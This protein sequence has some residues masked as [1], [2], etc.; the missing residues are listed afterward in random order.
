MIKIPLDDATWSLLEKEEKIDAVCDAF[1]AA[2][3]NGHFPRVSDYAA[4]LKEDQRKDLLR[5][6]MM[7]DKQY[8]EREA[9]PSPSP[10]QNSTTLS[11]QH[12]Q[13]DTEHE[14]VSDVPPKEPS[15]NRFELELPTNFGDF[16]L[17]K[18]L[19]KGSF[20]SVYRAEN[21]RTG[22]DVAIKIPHPKLVADRDDY[23][24]FE[25]EARNVAKLKHP[26]AVKIHH[27]GHVDNIPFLI[28][29]YIDGK[30]LKEF[31]SAFGK[32]PLQVV[33]KLMV[34]LAETVADAHLNGVI[35]RDIKPSNILIEGLPKSGYFDPSTTSLRPRLLDFGIAKLSGSN[36]VVTKHGVVLGTPAYMSPEQAKGNSRSV[37]ARSDIYSLGVVMYELL[38]G[39]TPFQ[40]GSSELVEQ[41]QNSEVPSIDT[42]KHSVPKDL[43]TI[44]QQAL[45]LDPEARYVSATEFANDL[46]RW[47]NHEPIHGRPFRLTEWLIKKSTKHRGE[48]VA[49][50]IIALI[51][52]A[53][54][55]MLVNSQR[56][57]RKQ[58]AAILVTDTK[59]HLGPIAPGRLED[60]LIDLP[61]S[62][63]DQRPLMEGIETADPLKL[64]K[65]GSALRPHQQAAVV[66][67]RHAFDA[68]ASHPQLQF[69]IACIQGVVD[70]E[71]F[72]S[73]G[74]SAQLVKWLVESNHL[75]D[76]D[77]LIELTNT[78]KQTLMKDLVALYGELNSSSQRSSTRQWLIGLLKDEP[79]ANMI[80]AMTRCQF[81]ELNEWKRLL[82]QNVA[83][84]LEAIHDKQLSL[85]SDF[86]H[87]ERGEELVVMNAKLLLM[88]YGLSANE[89]VWPKLTSA[90]DPRLRAYFVHQIDTTGF[91]LESLV[92][93]L[94]EESDPSIQYAIL[95]AISQSTQEKLGTSIV[96]KIRPWLL[97]AYQS[98]PDCG[99]HGMCR[100]ILNQ[101]EAAEAVAQIDDTLRTQGIINGRNWYVN[102]IGMTML[103]VPRP[104]EFQMAIESSSLSDATQATLENRRI[105]WAFAIATDEVSV[106]QYRIYDPTFHLP[107]DG[108]L[109]LEARE[110]HRFPVSD[111][112]WL[113]AMDFCHWLSRVEGVSEFD[114][115]NWEMMGIETLEIDFRKKGYRLPTKEE[116]EYTCRA[117]TTTDCSYGTIRT[118]YLKFYSSFTQ[119]PIDFRTQTGTRLPNGFGLF[120]CLGSVSE[121]TSSKFQPGLKRPAIAEFTE[122]LAIKKS[123]YIC[124]YN[125]LPKTPT[126]FRSI[127][128]V[129]KQSLKQTGFR[130]VHTLDLPSNSF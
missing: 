33:A 75:G 3:K 30:E 60:W 24:A 93:R 117:L 7:V 54:S 95:V 47:L 77:R 128:G 5:E 121:M 11:L 41:V 101:W 124:G 19:G 23:E 38:T 122:E 16:I 34:S 58:L 35:H 118:P 46:K 92:A 79:A 116:W 100:W 27:V 57:H 48:L 63:S 74:I 85:G 125:S 6:L 114:A 130:V 71:G 20:G 107:N 61:N 94:F 39:S 49:T 110:E 69:R 109:Q 50:S 31:W 36:T 104:V 40:G 25:R 44:C 106:E 12:C 4:I 81:E 70:Q 120:D 115:D 53:A 68:N 67:L 105:S 55:G 65:I 112:S 129:L 111:V 103:V 76:V 86:A 14:F 102:R 64:L 13:I 66:S 43:A 18:L 123:S 32:L 90:P 97:N 96:T 42:K 113:S 78:F 82:D 84:S 9:L 29:E 83:Q 52:L 87:D 2:W 28:M 91:E 72:K 45:R 22:L 127:F 108:P 10:L 15:P 62:L 8:Q 73:L 89:Q 99:V 98:H 80:D 17:L 126:S 21:I 119:K 51:V 56:L 1:E 59:N 88:Q 37:T 26:G